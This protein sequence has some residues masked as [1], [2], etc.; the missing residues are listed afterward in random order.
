MSFRRVFEEKSRLPC[1]WEWDFSEDLEMTPEQ[2]LS[3]FEVEKLGMGIH[4]S[5][6]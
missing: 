3:I 1:Q 2:L 4:A 5:T 6:H